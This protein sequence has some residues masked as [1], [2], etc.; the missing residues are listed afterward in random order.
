MN[1]VSES[2][3][4]SAVGSCIERIINEGGLSGFDVSLLKTKSLD[5]KNDCV[6]VGLGFFG[7]IEPIEGFEPTQVMGRITI[8]YYECRYDEQTQ[9]WIDVPFY[10]A[11]CDTSE[12]A[13]YWGVGEMTG[14]ADDFE[15]LQS[16]DG[17]SE[18][19]AYKNQMFVAEVG[20]YI[21]FSDSFADTLF[22]AATETAVTG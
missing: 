18:S 1:N 12:N 9:A 21:N 19:E 15:R 10:K 6:L 4:V 16:L 17:K 7:D 5:A 8:E 2:H 3:L 20:R 13:I 22:D 11:S 14:F